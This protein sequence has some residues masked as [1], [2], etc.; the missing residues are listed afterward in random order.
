LSGAGSFTSF[1]DDTSEA[2][3]MQLLTMS[4]RI[5]DENSP[6]IHL[7]QIENHPS[8]VLRNSP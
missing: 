8:V 5:V 3:Q 1:Q 4:K 6:G 2:G 7:S